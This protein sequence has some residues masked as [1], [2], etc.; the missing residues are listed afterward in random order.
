MSQTLTVKHMNEMMH[1]G[2]NLV[3]IA[4]TCDL[5][6]RDFIT[7]LIKG[8]KNSQEAELPQTLLS[9]FEEVLEANQSK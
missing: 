7:T 1:T 6:A 3:I 9:Y 5:L 4:N 2:P 8:E